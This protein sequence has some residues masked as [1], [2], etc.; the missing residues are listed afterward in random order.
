MDEAGVEQAG[1]APLRPYWMRSRGQ[2]AESLFRVTGALYRQGSSRCS[3]SCVCGLQGPG[4]QHC[5]PGA[6]W[7]RPA[8]PRLLRQRRPDQAEAAGGLSGAR[9]SHA[10]AA[11][12]EPATAAATPRRWWPSRPSSAGRRATAR[13]CGAGSAAHRMNRAGS[14]SHAGAGMAEYFKAAGHPDIDDLNVRRRSSSRRWRRWLRAPT[15]GASAATCMDAVDQPPTSCRRVRDGQLRVYGRTLSGSRRSSRWKRCVNDTRTPRELIGTLYVERAFAGDSKAKALEMIHD[16][17]AAFDANLTRRLDG[18]PTRCDPTQA[19]LCQ[20]DRIPGHV[21]R[22][23]IAALTPE[24]TSP[25][26]WPWQRSTSTL[27]DKSEAGDRNEWAGMPPQTVN[28][29]TT[30]SATRCCSRPASCNRF[31][32]PRLPAAMN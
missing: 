28:A 6:G 24:A 1:T 23:L 26:P 11:R 10:R 32:P 22:L 15:R 18:R 7:D 9:R 2:R 14:P 13:R 31:L 30:R 4:H 19:V 16:I 5:A 21:A 29:A 8:R 17:E 27:R 20:Q 3:G 12:Q 25:T